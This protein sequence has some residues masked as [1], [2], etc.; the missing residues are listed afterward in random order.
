[1]SCGHSD[2]FT[3]TEAQR[4]VLRMALVLNA[5]ILRHRPWRRCRAAIDLVAREVRRF[6]G[7]PILR[8]FGR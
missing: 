2:Q 4:R 7:I 3:E 8:I 6:V 1:M 5:A